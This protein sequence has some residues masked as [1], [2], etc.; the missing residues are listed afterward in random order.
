MV[1]AFIRSE[2]P[3]GSPEAYPEDELAQLNRGRQSREPFA[4]YASEH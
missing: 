1:L 3:E 2:L 4:P